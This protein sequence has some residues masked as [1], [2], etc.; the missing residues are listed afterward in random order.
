[1][2]RTS[3]VSE[4]TIQG[5]QFI[6]DSLELALQVSKGCFPGLI[7]IAVDSIVGPVALN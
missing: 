4:D 2:K 6:I 5:F 3:A 1:M 7:H